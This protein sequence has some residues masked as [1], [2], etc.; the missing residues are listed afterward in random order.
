MLKNCMYVMRRIYR[1]I[2]EERMRFHTPQGNKMVLSGFGCRDFC[3]VNGLL[4][5][6]SESMKRITEL[7]ATFVILF[8]IGMNLPSD[9]LGLMIGFCA[10]LL[11]FNLLPK[12]VDRLCKLMLRRKRR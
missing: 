8:F 12:G 9:A 1:H 4:P 11:V 5:I 7:F 6:V 3:W 2:F 10:V